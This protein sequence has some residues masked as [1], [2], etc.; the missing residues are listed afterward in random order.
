LQRNNEKNGLCR[1]TG[2]ASHPIFLP[3]I[4]FNDEKLVNFNA[5]TL[6]RFVA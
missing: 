6:Q 3:L 1:V 2:T 5:S 4:F